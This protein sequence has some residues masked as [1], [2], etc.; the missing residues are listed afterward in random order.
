[1]CV[2]ICVWWS[3]IFVRTTCKSQNLSRCHYLVR[4]NQVVNEESWVEVLLQVIIHVF[5]SVLSNSHLYSVKINVNKSLFDRSCSFLHHVVLLAF[6]LFIKIHHHQ[7]VTPWSSCVM[8]TDPYASVMDSLDCH[9]QMELPSLHVKEAWSAFTEILKERGIKHIRTSVYH[10]QAN[11]C[12][13]YLN[14]AVIDCIQAV[15]AAPQP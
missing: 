14:T 9:R 6:I 7:N 15:H 12:V 5:T 11:G 13:K 4:L 10:P 1:M 3:S 8:L 2:F